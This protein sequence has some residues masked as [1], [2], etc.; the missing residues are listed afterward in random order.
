[1]HD[2]IGS[3]QAFAET[4]R[5]E[6]SKFPEEDRDDVVILFSAHSIPMR[7]VNRGD[8][9]PPEV[10]STV[11]RVMEELQFSHSYRLVWQS[12]VKKNDVKRQK[13]LNLFITVKKL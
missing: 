12:K 13:K 10:G 5:E 4:I 6:L 11:Q 9:Y 1:M 8:P 3:V 7:A 2:V